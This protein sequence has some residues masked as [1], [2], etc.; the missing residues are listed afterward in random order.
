MVRSG[1]AMSIIH[2]LDGS[3]RRCSARLLAAR[4]VCFDLLCPCTVCPPVALHTY[5]AD[6]TIT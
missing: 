5:T 1:T 6:I 3:Q 2:L 4:Q